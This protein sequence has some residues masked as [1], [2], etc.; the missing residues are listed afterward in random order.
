MEPTM[1][2]PINFQQPYPPAQSMQPIPQTQAQ[3]PASGAS[4][5]SINIIEPKAYGNAPCPQA[6]APMAQPYNYPV[7]PMYNYAQAPYYAM[8]QTPIYGPQPSVYTPPVLNPLP[9]QAFNPEV[10]QQTSAAPVPPPPSLVDQQPSPAK[11]DNQKAVQPEQP[12]AQVDVAAI[13]KALTSANLDEQTSAIEKI[14]EI[15]QSNSPESM[16]LVNEDLFK[17]LTGVISADTS[18]LPDADKAKAEGNKIIGMWTMAVLQKNLR[19]AV[20]TELKAQNQPGLPLYELP[21]MVQI[22]KNIKSDPNPQVRSAGI[23]AV[24]YLAQPEDY[25]A[26]SDVLNTVVQTDKDATVK[27][28]AQS[29]LSSLPQS[30]ASEQAAQPTQT[31][32]QPA[33]VQPTQST[34]QEQ[35]PVQQVA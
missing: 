8:P 33:T 32:A 24:K 4:A 14:A 16:A 35:K 18:K 27:A 20:N 2:S 34:Q 6:A 12:A 1:G 10:M 3:A 5:V 28:D 30:Q 17:N 31:A 25:K 15:G 11:V 7:A 29:V 26:I 23:Q 22:E 21:G 9:Q 13:N 19:D